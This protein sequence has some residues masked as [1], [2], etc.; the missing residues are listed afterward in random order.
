M[1]AT[2]LLP[3]VV[4]SESGEIQVRRATRDDLDAVVN[5]L[6]DDAVSRARADGTDTAARHVYERAFEEIVED[7]RNDLL[8]AVDPDG[9]I[10][11]T[12]QLTSL[13]G[14]SRGGA[15]RLQVEAVRVSPDR[16]SSGIGSALMGWV[17]GIA[18]PAV[19]ARLVQLTSDMSRTDARR[20]Y[21][22][23][24][25]ADSHAGFK[26]FVTSSD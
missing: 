7:A 25:F 24:G 17:T 15:T 23:L 5:L 10:V 22:R 26:Y 3:D 8:V 14:M 4:E 12:L 6:R 18:A 1:I 9:E 19:G 16:R 11:G 13:P 20:F 21:L 2:L